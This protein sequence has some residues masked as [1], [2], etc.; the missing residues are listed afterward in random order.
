MA[1]PTIGTTPT[2]PRISSIQ[3]VG[4]SFPSLVTSR[5]AAKS[6]PVK[7]KIHTRHSLCGGFL[8]LTS[9]HVSFSPPSV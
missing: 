8:P 1:P 2:K 5:Y 6:K 3:L 9:I 4:K 7:N